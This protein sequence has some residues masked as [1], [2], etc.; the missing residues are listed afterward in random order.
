MVNREVDVRVRGS[1]DK[2]GDWWKE[3]ERGRGRVKGKGEGEGE[4]MS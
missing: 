2:I 4:G 3:G 1:E